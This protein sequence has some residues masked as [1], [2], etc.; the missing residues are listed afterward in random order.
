M[1]IGIVVAQ[2]WPDLVVR[3]DIW[4]FMRRLPVGC[5]TDSHQLYALFMSRLSQCI[6]VWDSEDIEQLKAAKRYE[7]LQESISL[8]SDVDV[9]HRISR[10]EMALHCRRTTRGEKETIA[11]ITEL[12]S[13]FDGDTGKDTL[14]VPLL[15]TQRMQDI[16]Q[17]QQKHVAC[18]Q[19]KPEFQLYIQTGTVLKG[20]IR[21]PKFRCAR[22][23]TSLE[24]CYLHMNRFIPGKYSECFV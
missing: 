9:L 23:S 14:G 16:W 8:P 15:N 13:A 18:I 24:S 2:D 21:L 19:D 22:G 17:K 20:G 6:F 3:M 1:L 7:M 11:L 12:L 4:H 5:T 10:S